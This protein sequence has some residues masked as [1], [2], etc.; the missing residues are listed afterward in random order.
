MERK[1]FKRWGIRDIGQAKIV[2][3]GLFQRRFH[4]EAEGRMRFEGRG[5]AHIKIKSRSRPIFLKNAT[6]GNIVG[7]S[8]VCPGSS[9]GRTGAAW[10][11]GSGILLGHQRGFGRGSLKGFVKREV[12]GSRE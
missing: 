8:Q 12:A 3:S 11:C 2:D 7:E 10:T 9:D 1:R 4:S 5:G 6:C